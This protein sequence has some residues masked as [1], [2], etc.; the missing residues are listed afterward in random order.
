MKVSHFK[1]SMFLECPLKYKFYYIDN[2][3][4]QCKPKPYHSM[5]ISVHDAL[6]KFFSQ[7]TRSLDVLHNLLRKHWVRE[8]FAG[9]NEERVWGLKALAMLTNF[10]HSVD[11]HTQPEMMEVS[12]EVELDGFILNGRI[13][14]VDKLSDGS[15][16]LIDYKTGNPMTYEEANSD[17]Q[18]SIYWLGLYHQHNIAPKKLTFY[19][20]KNNTTFTTEKSLEQIEEQKVFIKK[21]VVQMKEIKEFKPRPNRY[22]YL[23]DFALL[24]PLFANQKEEKKYEARW[25]CP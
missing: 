18:M 6:E 5:G 19:F 12:F 13:D 21:A 23:C 4:E 10:Y 1:L 20:L 2:L 25:F 11:V 22:C 8:G 15:Y 24:C 9:R 3:K 7:P 16:E 17:L 14:R